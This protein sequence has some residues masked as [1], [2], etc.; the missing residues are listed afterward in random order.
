M[1]KISLESGRRLYYTDQGK[2]EAIVLVHGWSGSSANFVFLRRALLASGYRVLSFDHQGHGNSDRPASAP[3]LTD[4]AKDL[5]ELLEAR[6]VQDFTL[7]AYS[8]GV[9]VTF[10]YLA[11]YPQSSVKELILVDMTPCLLADET[12]NTGL[13]KAGVRAADV[14]LLLGEMEQDFQSAWL[15]FYENVTGAP[16]ESEA[17]AMEML[18][19]YDKTTLVSLFGDMLEQDYRGEL[20]H[21]RMP[22]SHIYAE[23]GS[24]YAQAD[25]LAMRREIP[26]AKLYSIEDS[27][28]LLVITHHQEFNERVLSILQA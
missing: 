19:E 23:P 28:H 10:E 7:L 16:L 11:M 5:H 14:P 18:G 25:A 12:E 9:Y 8:M 24:L 17:V 27:T 20:G 21:L 26:Q 1:P 15:R 2:G 4:L 3:K 22:V 13:Y 6:Q